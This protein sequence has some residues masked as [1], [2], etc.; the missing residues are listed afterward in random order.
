MLYSQHDPK[1]FVAA[2]HLIGKT[3]GSVI[4]FGNLYPLL[5]KDQFHAYP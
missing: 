1:N 4:A 3:T 2:Q 5:A